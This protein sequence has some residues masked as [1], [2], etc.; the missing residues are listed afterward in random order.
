MRPLELL[1]RSSH[2]RAVEGRAAATAKNYSADTRRFLVWLDNRS[3]IP[4][5]TP[6]DIRSYLVALDDAGRS[7]S[8]RRGVSYALRA[9]YDFLIIEEIAKDNPAR[10]VPAIR[11]Y[12]PEIRPYSGNAMAEI[13]ESLPEDE[14][15]RGRLIAAMVLTL[16]Y[17]GIRAGELRG[18]K[19]QWLNLSERRL[20]VLGKGNKPRSLLLPKVLVDALDKYLTDVRPQ[21]PNSP[22]LFPNPDRR[23]GSDTHQFTLQSI[24][25]ITQRA[26]MRAGTASEKNNPHLWRHSFATDLLRRGTDIHKVQRLLGH[27]SI[28]TTTVYLH[29]V[30]D[31][32]QAA[33]DDAFGDGTED[34]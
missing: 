34:R 27:S 23:C 26:A 31:D 11:A 14:T 33:I 29:L 18:A 21:L 2:L 9:F 20:R 19:L 7:A 1:E 24:A 5:V 8:T 22:W 6:H 4:D 12:R 28:N 17:T 13:E 15:L 25:R 16:R 32:L 10:A 30:D 3:A